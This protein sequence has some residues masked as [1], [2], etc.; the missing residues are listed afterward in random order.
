MDG[1]S[2]LAVAARKRREAEVTVRLVVIGGKLQGVEAAYLGLKA[3]YEIVLVDRVQDVPASGLATETHVFDIG[4][5]EARARRLFMSCDAVLPACED[6]T[7]LGWL[8][9]RTRAWG[10]PLLFD[11]SAYSVSSSKLRSSR[12]FDD[13]SVPR[14]APWPGCS[15]PVIVKPSESSGSDGVRLVH[16]EDELAA[17]R[18]ELEARGHEAVVEEFA[19]GPSWSLEVIAWRGVARPLLAT[20]LEFDR[21]YDCKRVLAPVTGPEVGDRLARFAEIG[22]RLALGL[23]LSGVM[24]IEVMLNDGVLKVLEIDARLPSQTPTVVLHSC[25]VNM[26]ALLAET[27]LSGRIPSVDLTARQGCCYQH[28]RVSDGAVEVLG[29]HMMGTSGPLRL[30]RGLYG[31]DEVITDL[32]AMSSRGLAREWVATMIAVAP[33]AEGARSKA[34]AALAR[35]AEDHG[36]TIEPESSPSRSTWTPPSAPDRI[37]RRRAAVGT[38]SSRL[39]PCHASRCSAGNSAVA[40]ADPAE[41]HT[42]GRPAGRP[43]A[44]AC[45]PRGGDEPVRRRRR[46]RF[47]G[48]VADKSSDAVPTTS[49]TQARPDRPGVPQRER[50]RGRGA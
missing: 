43:C 50:G 37:G 24:D 19:P 25:G 6:Q 39:R 22:E 27:V 33:D 4:E 41:R 15:F 35:L 2:A 1:D 18:D 46:L 3:G 45:R 12:L 36:L 20:E 44:W 31:A 13:L 49:Q 28:V 23:G 47:S 10:V 5:D 26:V 17:V 30:V 40:S 9:Q 42:L 21:L 32:P 7:T 16:D 8:T 29:E 14:P 11:L 48:Q 38:R 34:Q